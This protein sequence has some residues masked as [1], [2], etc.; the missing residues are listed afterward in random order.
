MRWRGEVW[1]AKLQMQDVVTAI[2]QRA[3]AKH[4][5]GLLCRERRIRPGHGR[6]S[7]SMVVYVAE[8]AY[9]A[10]R[11][12]GAQLL[13]ILSIVK[14]PMTSTFKPKAINAMMATVAPLCRLE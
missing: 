4:R 7:P 2:D 14:M 9:C 12:E 6:R 1:L 5:V 13:S 8:P 11:A 3:D 10:K